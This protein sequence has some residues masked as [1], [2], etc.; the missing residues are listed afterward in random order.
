MLKEIVYMLKNVIIEFG[1]S[2]WSSQYVLVPRPGGTVRFCT[3][4]RKVNAVTQ[5]D[6]YYITRTG[7][8][9][10]DK[11]VK[12]NSRWPDVIYSLVIFVF[13]LSMSRDLCICHPR[14]LIQLSCDV[15]WN[16]KYQPTSSGWEINVFNSMAS[17][18]MPVLLRYTMI[19]RE[20]A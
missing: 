16:E 10:I 13:H 14:W 18:Y 9:C 8:C 1:K 2:D 7:Y 20:S 6:S 4:Y 19:P 5:T 3:D 15:I 17:V 12:A 11:I